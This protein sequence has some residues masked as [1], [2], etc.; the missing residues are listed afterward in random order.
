MTNYE[1]M[2]H[3]SRVRGLKY[4]DQVD[5]AS[6]AFTSHPSRVRGL[7][8]TILRDDDSSSGLSHPSRVRGLKFFRHPVV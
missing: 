8:C 6:D 5:A 7:K 4:D 1:A 2:S 3:P